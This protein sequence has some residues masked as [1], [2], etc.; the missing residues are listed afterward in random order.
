[1]VVVRKNLIGKV[2][3]T[4]ELTGTP[5]DPSDQWSVSQNL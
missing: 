2:Y 3:N 5:F 4:G 1:M